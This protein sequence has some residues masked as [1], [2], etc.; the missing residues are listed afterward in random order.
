MSISIISIVY[1]EENRIDKFISNLEPFNDVI[2]IDKSSTD[3]TQERILKYKATLIKTDYSE[4]VKELLELGLTKAKHE[5]IMILTCSDLID[6]DLSLKL[7]ELSK[8]LIESKFDIITVPYK[9]YVL[10]HFKRY[11]PWFQKDYETNFV[12]IK[13]NNLKLTNNLHSEIQ[14]Y[15]DNLYHDKTLYKY[16]YIHHLTHPNLDFMFDRT[17]RYASIEKIAKATQP[18]YKSL[19]IMFYDIIRIVIN[20]NFR[21]LTPKGFYLFIAILTYHFTIYLYIQE[22]RFNISNKIYNELESNE[23]TT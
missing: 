19:T 4:N 1:N 12:L 18:N 23:T 8:D 20:K 16:G 3:K 2:I 10:G 17:L 13:R 11:S 7:L 9:R 21:L 14:T 5:W 22:Q 15:N 6:R